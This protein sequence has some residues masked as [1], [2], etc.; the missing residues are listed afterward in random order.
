MPSR[1]RLP[2][3]RHQTQGRSTTTRLRVFSCP[4]HPDRLGATGRRVG[5]QPSCQA[6]RRLPGSAPRHAPTRRTCRSDFR[7]LGDGRPRAPQRTSPRR[8]GPPGPSKTHVLRQ[9]AHVHGPALL[10]DLHIPRYGLH[11]DP[12]VLWPGRLGGRPTPTARHASGGGPPPH[13]PRRSGHHPVTDAS[14]GA[15]VPNLILLRHSVSY[16]PLQGVRPWTLGWRCFARMRSA[17]A[18]AGGAR[19]TRLS[20]L[21][22]MATRTTSELRGYRRAWAS[23]RRCL[24][25]RMPSI[26]TAC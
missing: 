1:Y 2:H 15:G 22:M 13:I 18:L 8:P 12:L 10:H 7:H 23:R 21:S 16:R 3:A 6:C 5:C 19:P 9:T 17:S 26:G 4:L 20:L 24:S 11:S 14:G 25:R